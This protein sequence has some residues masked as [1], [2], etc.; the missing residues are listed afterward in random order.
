MDHLYRNLTILVWNS[1]LIMIFLKIK[2]P[3]TFC[4]FNFEKLQKKSL[5]QFMSNPVL[6][7]LFAFI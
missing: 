3:N 2:F 5:P 7:K 1:T 4:S 6:R